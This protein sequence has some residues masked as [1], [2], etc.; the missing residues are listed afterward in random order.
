MF[1]ES[2]KGNIFLCD[3]SDFNPY[4]LDCLGLFFPFLSHAKQIQPVS[5]RLNCLYV[6]CPTKLPLLL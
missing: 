5:C 1:L 3:P 4:L 6:S 2:E